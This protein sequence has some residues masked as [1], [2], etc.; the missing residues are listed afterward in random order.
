MRRSEGRMYTNLRTIPISSNTFGTSNADR[1]RLRFSRKRMC[2]QTKGFQGDCP[3]TSIY[4]SSNASSVIIFIR[5]LKNCRWDIKKEKIH[6]TI[7]LFNNCT[8][9]VILYI[10]NLICAVQLNCY[11]S[12]ESFKK[13]TLMCCSSSEI[14]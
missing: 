8:V 14:L 4:H 6:V 5:S 9:Y 1:P 10:E 7:L 2:V 11:T 3:R 13:R 12:W